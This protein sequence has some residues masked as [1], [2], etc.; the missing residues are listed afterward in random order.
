MSLNQELYIDRQGVIH[1]RG[2]II[3]PTLSRK[4]RVETKDGWFHKEFDSQ[5]EACKYI[6]DRTK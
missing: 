5:V 4:F 2:Y 6:V 1:L 3:I